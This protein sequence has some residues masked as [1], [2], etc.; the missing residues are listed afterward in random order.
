MSASKRHYDEWRTEVLTRVDPRRTALLVIDLQRDFCSPTGALAALGS[1]VSPSSA[2]A[3]RIDRFLP[4]VREQ[5]ALVAFFK[6]V[7]DPKTMSAAQRER[8]LRDGRP[9]LCDPTTAGCDL[10]LSPASSD[11]VFS[12]WA[13]RSENR[14]NAARKVDHLRA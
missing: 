2:V 13:R 11:L 9:I 6:L 5:L 10:V 3:S 14:P 12:K 8:L 1:D 7:Y 4:S